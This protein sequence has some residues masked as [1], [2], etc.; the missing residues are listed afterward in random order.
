MKKLTCSIGDKFGDWTVIGDTFSKNGHTYVTVQC[1]CG[2]VSNLCLSDLIHNR[3]HS[4]RKCSARRRGHIHELHV[5]D[6]IKKW[7]II[8]GPRVRNSTVQFKVQCE[9]GSSRWI[10]PNELLNP[11]KCFSCIKCSHKPSEQLMINQYNRIKR[12]AENRG[13]EFDVSIEY[14]WNL[15]IKQNRTCSITGDIFKTI[16]EA[17][18]D[19]IDSSIG[20]IEGNVQWVTYRANVSKH[21]MTMSELYEFCLK[22]VNHANQQPSQT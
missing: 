21:T 7:T 17:S 13:L 15:F 4:C 8:E 19:R 14:L 20:Y 18:L 2:K 16:R 11:N 12:S 10:Q 6:K 5:G 3:A 1:N 22:V 9:C